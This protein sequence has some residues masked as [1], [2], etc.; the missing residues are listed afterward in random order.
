LT[1]VKQLIMNKLI[2]KQQKEVG[3]LRTEDLKEMTEEVR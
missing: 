2:E 1:E 3:F